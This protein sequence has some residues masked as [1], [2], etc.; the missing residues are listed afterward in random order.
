MA[1]ADRFDGFL[2][3]LDGV[4][5]EGRELIPGAV[6][7]LRKLIES[8]KE[9]VF[10]TNNSV[11]APAAYGARLR[12]AGVE[13]ADDRVVTAGA[14]TARLA[15]ESVGGG[16]TAFVIGAPGF[17][18]T[19]AA[20]GL[21]LLDGEAARSAGTVIVSGHREFDY[22]ELLTATFAL[23]AGAALFGTSRDPTLPMPGGAWPGTGATLAAVETASGKTAEIG[24]KPERH[25]FDQ[26]RALI[27]D[28]ER[29]AMVGDRIASDI[30]GGRRAG[31][32]TILV[33]SGA[34]SREQA[35]A[36]DPKPERVLE[37]LAG[38]LT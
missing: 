8:N 14:A 2:V 9:I 31:L 26:A 11:K 4:V 35:E 3:D 18:E 37:D 20:A 24:G 12:D 25:L 36:A 1:L 33:L 19:V 23:R 27:G 6:E 32:E 21:V 30:E 34:S 38:L 16:G 5:W 10:V 7:T 28:A 13:I 15:A 17:K 29:V 22:G